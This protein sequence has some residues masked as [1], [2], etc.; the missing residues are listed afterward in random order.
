[1][2][3]INEEVQGSKIPSYGAGVS[4]GYLV[5]VKADTEYYNKKELDKTDAALRVPNAAI[6]FVFDNKKEGALQRRHEETYYGIN[7]FD[8]TNEKHQKAVNIQSSKIKHMVEAYLGKF[9][10]M[11]E[12]AN[13]GEFYT[14]LANIFNG[15]ADR[16][17]LKVWLFLTYDSSNR[18]HFGNPNFLEKMVK[19][20]PPSLKAIPGIHKIT[21]TI[22]NVHNPGGGGGSQDFPDFPADMGGGDDSPPF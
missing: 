15:I 17:N 4:G 18:L 5:E 1:M 13:Y 11:K 9:P 2:L 10:P 7:N 8:K 3:Q 20:V 6:T 12:C 21:P 22:A 19:D 14:E 16:A